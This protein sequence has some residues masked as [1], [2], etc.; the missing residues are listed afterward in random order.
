MLR[1]CRRFHYIVDWGVD[2]IPPTWIGNR[3]CIN[4]HDILGRI[5]YGTKS[6]QS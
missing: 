1:H 2:S 6:V 5:M 4:Q 3:Y